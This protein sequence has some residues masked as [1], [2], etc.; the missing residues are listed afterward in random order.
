MGA[1]VEP[2]PMGSM[3]APPDPVP[4]LWTDAPDE[5]VPVLGVG[6]DGVPPEFP[7]L[8]DEPPPRS[9]PRRPPMTPPWLLEPPPWPVEPLP[10]P[11]PVAPIPG[12]PVPVDPVPPVVL[13]T[14]VG[15]PAPAPPLESSSFWLSEL[16]PALPP[17]APPPGSAQ[18]GAEAIA[19][20]AK[21]TATTALSRFAKC[22]D[23]D[24]PPLPPILRVRR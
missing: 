11:I 5:P 13:S 15:L 3:G 19:P 4:G 9:P 2:V 22:V 17:L 21:A 12:D 6:I 18:A 16:P 24:T 8:L 1:P 23:V 10:P 20:I 7:L 14:P